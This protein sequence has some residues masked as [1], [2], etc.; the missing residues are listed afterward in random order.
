MLPSLW[1][2]TL[3]EAESRKISDET[4]LS[5]SYCN[6]GPSLSSD[7]EFPAYNSLLSVTTAFLDHC[8]IS[9]IS[10]SFEFHHLQ[11]LFL[12][13]NSITVID[14]ALPLFKRVE[15]LSL[16]GNRLSSISNICCFRHLRVLKLADNSFSSLSSFSSTTAQVNRT[17]EV[18]VLSCNDVSDLTE[19]QSLS[20]LQYL[21]N[22]DLRGNPVM[23]CHG[24]NFSNFSSS[25]QHLKFF[26]GSAT[27]SV[28]DFASYDDNES[29]AV[30]T[31][32]SP[33]RHQ[34]NLIDRV[35][36][37]NSPEL[38]SNLIESGQI[39]DGDDFQADFIEHTVED[40]HTETLDV[41]KN[42]EVIDADEFQ[43]DLIEDTT[44]NISDD[45]NLNDQND[46]NSNAEEFQSNFIE[47]LI[48]D[49]GEMMWKSMTDN[50]KRDLLQVFL[51]QE[52]LD[53][54]DVVKAIKSIEKE[55]IDLDEDLLEPSPAKPMAAAQAELKAVEEL[56]LPEIDS[57]LDFE[58]LDDVSGSESEN[59][60][61]FD[62]IS[63]FSDSSLTDLAELISDDSDD[64]VMGP[65]NEGQNEDFNGQND[66]D[67]IVNDAAQK[68]GITDEQAH[69]AAQKDEIVA[70][71]DSDR[72]GRLLS[73]AKS[74]Y[75]SIQSES[76]EPL[77]NS[78]KKE[79]TQ[80]SVENQPL[81]AVEIIKKIKNERAKAKQYGTVPHFSSEISMDASVQDR[82]SRIRKLQAAILDS[83]TM[84]MSLSV[85]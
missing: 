46:Q 31:V 71:K 29:D 67:D 1:L 75:S 10:P 79:E 66:N 62:Q 36:P 53:G 60:N 2:Q 14:A 52:G 37:Y 24:G 80:T 43:S 77:L 20:C 41:I 6:L 44:T 40:F 11:E 68:D 9:T 69:I 64:D 65:L 4:T 39:S 21:K 3:S 35:S 18:L 73:S 16:C 28:S 50:Q 49:D 84:K 63:N 54:V 56:S 74:I 22:L 58:H 13:Y 12:D 72:I 42:D 70:Q 45:P 78:E 47:D 30:L 61:I 7:I 17:L 38:Q 83:A 34:S 81:S 76:S 33:F 55:S 5:L 26:N 27:S 32:S 15:Y 25:F 82:I 59:S 85:D 8:S 48:E 19:L 23:E 57:D 51:K